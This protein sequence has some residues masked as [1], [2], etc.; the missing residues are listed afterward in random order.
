MRRSPRTIYLVQCVAKKRHRPTQARDLYCSPWFLKARS[1]VEAREA[2]WF[3]L[4]GKH[5]VVAPETVLAPYN[6]TLNKTS[7]SRR[8][9]WADKVALG[10][11]RHC[12]A[13]DRVVLL[14]GHA[15]REH[16]EDR[17]RSWGC[18]VDAP[19]ARLG[20]GRQLRWLESR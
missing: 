11:R 6:V 17:L 4:S 15:Y 10:L 9:A 5:G 20:I 2:P 7:A 8:R 3:I 18:R 12:K 1:F 14:A 19:L 16:L 13:G